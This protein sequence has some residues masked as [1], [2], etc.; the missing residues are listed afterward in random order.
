VRY[1]L[2]RQPC[3]RKVPVCPTRSLVWRFCFASRVENKVSLFSSDDVMIYVGTWRRRTLKH[4]LDSITCDI[5][6][7]YQNKESMFNCLRFKALY[8]RRQDLDALFLTNVFKNRINYC[9]NM[10]T[11]ALRVP[12]KQTRDYSTFNVSN[13]SRLSPSARC[14]TAASLRTF[15]IDILSPQTNKQTRWL[16]SA[17][18]RCRPSGRRL[19]AK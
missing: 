13:A 11:V 18:E 2:S 9:S 6:I 4:A 5:Q 19:L 10:D 7:L 8:P 1:I 17:S 15:S 14:V 16:W 12:T 3:G